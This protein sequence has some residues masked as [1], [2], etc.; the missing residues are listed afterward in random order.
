MELFF[1]MLVPLIIAAVA[2]YGCLLY[3]S[4]QTRMTAQARA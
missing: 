3:T 2:L 1:T 4:L